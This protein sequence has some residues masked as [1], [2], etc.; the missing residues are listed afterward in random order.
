MKPKLLPFLTLAMSISF[1]SQGQNVP[2]TWTPST[3]ITAHYGGGMMYYSYDILITDTLS[4]MKILSNKGA[5]NYS[6]KFTKTE[7]DSILAFFD[8]HRFHKIKSEFAGLAHDKASESVTL[9][10]ENNLVSASESAS[11][12]VT[13]KYRDDFRTVQT[14]VQDL[15][16]KDK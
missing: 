4:Y 6:R 7:L 16:R 8:A 9:S 5:E 1:F 12:R 2:K 11:M 13:E 10:W 15:F 14:Y 3:K